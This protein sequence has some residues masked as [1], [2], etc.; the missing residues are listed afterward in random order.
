M[1]AR[2]AHRRC[3]LASEGG[4]DSEAGRPPGTPLNREAG[5]ATLI[6]IVKLVARADRDRVRIAPSKGA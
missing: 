1:P 4:N 5:R 3:S 2:S 6:C